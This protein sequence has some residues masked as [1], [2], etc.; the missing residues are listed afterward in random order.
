[1]NTGNMAAAIDIG[2]HSVR[3]LIGCCDGIKITGEKH[4]TI[5]RLGEGL[6]QT[7][8][9]NPQ[10]IQ[11]TIT[12]VREFVGSAK[13]QGVEGS[14]FCYATSAAR[15]AK[16][17]DELLSRLKEIDGLVPEIIDGEAEALLAY[18]GASMHGDV[19]MDIGGGSTELIR[20]KDGAFCSCSVPLGTVTSLERFLGDFDDISP[21]ML[22]A[23]AERG[24]PLVERLCQTVLGNDKAA[25]LV[26]VGGTA[27]QLAMLFLGLPEYDAKQVNGYQ[28]SLH[29]LEKL[30][31]RLINMTAKAR[32]E[33]P[34]MHPKRAD[35]IVAGC[36][37]ACMV[38]ARAGAD[39]L[40]ASDFDGL[41]A[42]L[43]NK[44]R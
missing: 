29:E 30:Q 36:L 9:L 22:L 26:G 28:M 34:G 31:T 37:I 43:L 40:I 39:V 18:Q 20:M 32:I 7:G 10:A 23:M 25:A 27:T 16:N 19:V 17:G 5:T 38:M 33:M 3:M 2:T 12:A 35:V 11:R 42:Y 24:R 13:A 44:C 4:L 15:E 21:L 41:D 14:V 8:V 6:V 1:M